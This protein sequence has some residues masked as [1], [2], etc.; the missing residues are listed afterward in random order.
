MPKAKYRR[1]R[2][3][4]TYCRYCG[5]EFQDSQKRG[6]HLSSCKMNPN[7]KER[8]RKLS[9]IGKNRII[10]LE[11]KTKISN[12]MKKAHKE[13]KA[14]NI[15]KSRWNNK[16]SYPEKF[17]TKV[18][19]NEFFDKDFIPEFPIGIYSLDFAWPHKKKS[20]EIDGEQHERFEEYIERDKRKNILVESE[21]WT[22]LRIKWKDMHND[23]KNWIAKAKEYIGV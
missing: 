2:F 19:N 11:S 16:Q 18:I 23:T 5:K 22:I 17:F 20:I 21:G 15:G 14:W 12:S 9:E 7:Y 4:L 3:T 13:G 1:K 10:S 8:S 6:G